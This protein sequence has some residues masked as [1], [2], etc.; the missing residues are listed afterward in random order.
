VPLS[1][2]LLRQSKMHMKEGNLVMADFL[3]VEDVFAT[4]A[5]INL[6]TLFL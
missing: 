2:P 6:N 3:V 4:T 1:S 5:L